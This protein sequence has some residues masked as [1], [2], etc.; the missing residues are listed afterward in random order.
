[1]ETKCYYL[2]NSGS[3]WIVL[4]ESGKREKRE[5]IT[6]SGHVVARRVIYYEMFGNFAAAFISYKGK[7]M[8]VLADTILDD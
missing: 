2:N 1:M 4:D 7:R 6:K 8:H 5:W 3:R